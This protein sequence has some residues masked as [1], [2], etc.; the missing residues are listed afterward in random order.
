VSLADDV[1]L[2]GSG[3]SSSRRRRAL[4]NGQI[5]VAV[6]GLGKMGLPLA[7]VFADVTGNVIG[8]DTDP[9]VA[10]AVARGECPVEREPGLPE[11][12]RAQV[13]AGALDATASPVQAAEQAELHVV[14]VPVGVDP[15]D[16]VSLA[17]LT[18]ATRAIASGLDPGDL[19]VVESTVPPGTCS[20]AVHPLLEA[21]S[22]LQRGE[23]GLACCPER[24][25]TGRALT[26]IRGAYPRIVGGVDEPS[27]RAAV[28]VY[29]QLTSN[30]VIP[31][32]D[33]TTAE[34]VKVFEGVYRDVNIALANE[35]ARFTDDLEIDV[36]EAIEAANTQP[37]C[38]IHTPGVGVGGHCI[39][40]YPQF[41]IE[42]VASAAP[43]LRTAR[44][45]NDGMPDFAVRKLADLLAEEGT[46]LADA[47]V[48]VL[49]IAYRPHVDE[50]SNSPGI[51]VAERLWDRGAEVLAVDPVVSGL[52]LAGALIE[53]EEAYRRPLDGVVL[54]TFHDAFA[55][56]DWTALGGTDGLAVVDGRQALDLDGTAHR[57]YTIGG[58]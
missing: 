12:V 37:Y 24:T 20:E 16:S 7:A 3:A 35:L 31:V 55:D 4:T 49:G 34:A 27:T 17:S 19:V 45:V 29:D 25:M 26:D 50:V 42:E 30:E 51:A 8:A 22:G 52:D 48:L 10:R 23:F 41:L 32:S 54:A 5:P 13:E 2:Y 6:Y 38:D 57:V 44:A 58:G 15:D 14:L 11:L 53:L 18:A 40:V 1:T 56:I 43:L 28:D 47:T 36:T 39:P 46:D 33:M 21:E 9:S